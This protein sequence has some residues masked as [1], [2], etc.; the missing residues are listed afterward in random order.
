MAS[1]SCSNSLNRASAALALC[2]L[3]VACVSTPRWDNKEA[4]RDFVDGTRVLAELH[5]SFTRQEILSACSERDGFLCGWRE[6]LLDIGYEDKDIVD[7]SEVTTDTYCYGHNSGVGC[8]HL[9]VYIAH[10]PPSLHGKLTSKYERRGGKLHALRDHGDLVELELKRTPTNHLAGV[11]VGVH[12]RH[13]EWGDC[14]YQELTQ[15]A[16]GALYAFSSIGPPV[17]LWIECDEA[18]AAGWT[19]RAVRGAPPPGVLTGAP[20]LSEW[21][22]PGA[23][24]VDGVVR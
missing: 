1:I 17:G 16:L 3:L 19:R 4:N 5:A 20:P 23:R 21:I 11:V 6:K 22:K 18:E 8:A 10:V 15:G 12:R 2:L 9:G 13:G 24:E 7:G 14:R